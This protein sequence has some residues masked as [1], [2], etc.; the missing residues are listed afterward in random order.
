MVV[1]LKKP[2]IFFFLR[3]Q[4]D[5]LGEETFFIKYL[6]LYVFYISSINE[7]ARDSFQLI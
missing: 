4:P 6:P 2:K 3:Q 1:V 7:I 5:F